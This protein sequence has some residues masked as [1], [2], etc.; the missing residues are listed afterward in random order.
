MKKKIT[1]LIIDDEHHS[2]ALIK[3]YL[4]KHK[5]Y[6]LVGECE[7]GFQG[8]ISI[9]ELKPDIVFLDI[10][11]PKL[12]GFEMLELID[13]PPQI[14]FSTAFDTFAIK[15]FEHG[16]IDYL[17]KPFSQM[18]FDKALLKIQNNISK[19]QKSNL[20]TNNLLKHITQ[21]QD[22]IKRI[23]VKNNNKIEIILTNNISRIEAQDDYVFIYTI[24]GNRVLKNTTMTYLESHLD[25]IEFVRVHRSNIIRINQIS[26]I[27]LWEK[28][29]HI[30]ILKS[31]DK[32]KTSRNG[33]KKLKES[34][35]V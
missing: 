27:E 33:Y 26:K 3:Q 12:N 8:A 24:D 22:I 30:V 19:G 18:R 21:E 1:V 7:N 4:K 23:V 11:M 15:A 29:S 5:S 35:K 6:E 25:P 31:G 32:I 34:L 13:N 10:Q 9:K 28:E 20:A 16:A 2:R 14:I 17:L